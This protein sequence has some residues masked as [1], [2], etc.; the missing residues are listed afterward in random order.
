MQAF[1]RLVFKRVWSVLIVIGSAFSF[2]LNPAFSVQLSQSSSCQSG[3]A[4]VLE[5]SGQTQYPCQNVELLAR[6][7]LAKSG[8]ESQ[9]GNDIWGWTDSET[10]R[11]Y[12]L[13][14]L[15]NKTA[16]VDMTDPKNPVH[17]ADLLTHS[18]SSLWRDIKVYKNAAY[19]VSEAPGHG[20]QIYDL[21]E[22]RGL[23]PKAM[24][25]KVKETSSYPYFETAH[26]IAIDEVS[27]YGYAVGTNTCDSGV[28]VVDLRDPLNPQFVN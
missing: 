14:G 25:V 3:F 20:I 28:H 21:T 11:E 16:F 2:F 9:E 27:G 23:D 5:V 10:G 17:V 24:P 1:N 18:V 4:Q 12:V 26:N 6:V 19:I 15:N 13:M 7:D 8:V 22:L